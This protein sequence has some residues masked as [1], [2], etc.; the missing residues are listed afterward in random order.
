[1]PTRSEQDSRKYCVR[2]DAVVQ[3]GLENNIH[4]LLRCHAV[5]V[6]N[7]VYSMASRSDMSF[8]PGVLESKLI[9]KLQEVVFL[10]APLLTIC[11]KRKGQENPDTASNRERRRWCW[12]D[13]PTAR[14]RRTRFPKR[15][16]CRV[17][18]KRK[19]ST[20]MVRMASS[21]PRG[22]IGFY[23]R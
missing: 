22:Y 2:C 7:L 18:P 6:E 9:L 17:C 8:H 4:D 5:Y 23:S 3:G 12:N 1:M 20:K 19:S 10:Q 16:I 15:G 21:V 13:T 11:Q 14:Q